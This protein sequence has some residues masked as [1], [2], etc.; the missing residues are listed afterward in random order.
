MRDVDEVDT[1]TTARQLG[2]TATNV[3][4][5]LH[6]ART[7]LRRESALALT[8]RSAAHLQAKIQHDSDNAHAS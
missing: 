5:R 1:A 3:K 6:R 4:V 8:S 7:M 2:I